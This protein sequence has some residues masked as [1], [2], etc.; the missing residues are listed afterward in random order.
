MRVT[1]VSVGLSTLKLSWIFNG[2][3][4][5]HFAE[6]NE[7]FAFATKM[8]ELSETNEDCDAS[9]DIEIFEVKFLGEM[10]VEEARSD[11][12]TAQSIKNIITEAKG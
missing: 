7:E 8:A 5:S 9:S 12:I 11:K 3:F 6:L 1:K 4:A 2:I 10:F